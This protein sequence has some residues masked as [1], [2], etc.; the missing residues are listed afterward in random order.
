MGAVMAEQT[1]S[2]LKNPPTNCKYAPILRISGKMLAFLILF[3][4]IDEPNLLR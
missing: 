2:C 4:I 3:S 1:I